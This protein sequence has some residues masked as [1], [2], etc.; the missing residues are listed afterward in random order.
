MYM[1]HVWG[2]DKRYKAEDGNGGKFDNY[3]RH[4]ILHKKQFAAYSRFLIR[5]YQMELTITKIENR[6]SKM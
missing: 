2:V 1:Y 5:M 6:Q 4:F 3:D